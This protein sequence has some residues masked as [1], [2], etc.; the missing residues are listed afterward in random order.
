MIRPPGR[1]RVRFPDRTADLTELRLE[2]DADT[3]LIGV[4]I[5]ALAT[6]FAIDRFSTAVDMGRCSALLA[7][8][9]TV[10]LTHC[11][12]DHVA[13][14]IAW[15]SAHTRRHRG[16]PTRVVVPSGKRSAL[17]A[18]LE[19]WPDLDGVRRRVDLAEAL[20]G[21]EPGTTVELA[22]GGAATAFSVRHNTTALGWSVTSPESDRPVVAIAGDSTV[23]PFREDP[24][25]LDAS[26]AVVDCSFIETGTRVAARLGGHGHLD[27][28]L[29][30]LPDLRCDFLV[31]AHLQPGTTA[32]TLL[33]RLPEDLPG[34]AIVVPWVARAG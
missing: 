27:D 29:E 18:A 16:Q 24:G 1:E 3:S 32:E 9:E 11:H 19:I 13:G 4:S 12:S 5:A 17:L 26:V 21:A 2:P 7:A 34:T 28:W 33:D 22:G 31:L 15:L 6:A 30:L 10:L 25:L 14:L 8:Q 20:V 23:E